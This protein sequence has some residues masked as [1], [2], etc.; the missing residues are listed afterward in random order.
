MSNSLKRIRRL[1]SRFPLVYELGAALK[2]VW[3]K[4]SYSG[5]DAIAAIKLVPANEGLAV[6]IGANRGQSAIR[7]LKLKPKFKVMAFEP[8]R[9]CLPFLKMVKLMHA[10][11]F[12]YEL[13]GLSDMSGNKT[14]YE[15]Q[16]N[17]IAVAAEGTFC[18][19]NLEPELAERIGNYKVRERT[20]PVRTLDEM[21][22]SPLFVKIDVQGGE[23]EV[24]RGARRTISR[25]R[26]VVVVERNV[27]NESGV[28][29]YFND[30]GYVRITS[31]AAGVPVGV[32]NGD[33]V[34]IH[35]AAALYPSSTRCHNRQLSNAH[36]GQ[37]LD[38][39]SGAQRS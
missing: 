26:P 28:I 15:P 3:T 4:L 12:H 31:D 21:N 35:P 9:R 10:G 27:L 38:Q 23:L 16:V 5:G 11:S 1:L 37:H 17:S 30:L 36:A 32:L 7:I 29:S 19:Q 13:C 2:L 25:C 20:F 22:L 33:N 39:E 18:L 8:N 6:D 14:Y 34:F 24:L